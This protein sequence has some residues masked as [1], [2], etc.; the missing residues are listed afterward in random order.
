MILR[1]SLLCRQFLMNQ[2]TGNL[3]L[4]D[5]VD[6]IGVPT[7]PPGE[8]VGIRA[9]LNFVG[10][11]VGSDSEPSASVDFKVRTPD[12]EDIQFA[13]AT[14][15]FEKAQDYTVRFHLPLKTLPL[16]GVGRYHFLVLKENGEVVGATPYDVAIGD[17]PPKFPD[18]SLEIDG[19]RPKRKSSKKLSGN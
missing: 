17:G 2:E 12:G 13:N 3:S 15:Q 19:Q 7:A 11:I 10:C 18:T 9:E 5:V 8:L 6:T 1:W 4:I 16:K 14:L